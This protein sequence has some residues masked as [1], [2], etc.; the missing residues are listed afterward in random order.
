M[1]IAHVLPY[2][3][4]FPLRKH[5]G[6][7]EWALR[8]AAAQAADG[9]DVTIYAGPSVPTDHNSISFKS[10]VQTDD[11]DKTTTNSRL[12]LQAFAASEHQL[13]HSHFDSLHFDLADQTARSVVATQHWFPTKDIA[14]SV[15]RN[16]HHNVVTVPVTRYMASADKKLSIPTADYI[17]HGIDLELF[18][19]SLEPRSDRLL[20]VGRIAPHKGVYEV[21]RAVQAAGATL[22]I[23]GKINPADQAYWETILPM[24]D[25]ERIAYHGSQNQKQVAAFM[26]RARGMVFF[27]QHEEAFGQTIIEAQACG[28]PVILNS[29]GA[30]SELV[31]AGVTGVIA[32]DPSTFQ[33]ALTIIDSLDPLNCRNFAERFD[34]ATMVKRYYELYDTLV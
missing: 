3:A 31:Q 30:N 4:A 24:V 22:D 17:Y 1:N 21:V 13:Y 12:M 33:T 8:L 11:R 2:G 10:L 6:R 15:P 16:T 5:N 26:A 25:G 23:V 34:F 28:T 19:T 27:P 18:K 32:D 7:Y 9:H 29:V 20:F 14:A